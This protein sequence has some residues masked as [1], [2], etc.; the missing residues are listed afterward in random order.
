MEKS[1]PVQTLIGSKELPFYLRCLRSLL[2]NSE[3]RIELL[4]HTDKTFSKSTKD[5]VLA[6]FNQET[7]S[8]T[9]PIENEQKTLDH[10]SG[11]PLSQKIRRDSIWGI[12][13]FDPIFA[14]PNDPIS[15]YIDADILFLRPFSGLFNKSVV[16]GGALFIRDAQWDAYCIR[17]WHLLGIGMKPK[18]VQGITTALVCWDKR[19]IDWDYLEWFLGST[20]L[21]VIPEW[22]LPTAQAGLASMCDAKTISPHQ[23]TNLYP[24]A[25][26]TRD[27]FGVHLLGSYRKDW[28]ERLELDLE[29]QK[30]RKT[31]IRAR[32]EVC[33]KRYAF[34]YALNQIKRWVNTRLNYW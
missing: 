27:T 9:D 18:I 34:G 4:L 6:S 26:I 30:E 31:T 7:I 28:L 1:I 8:F 12:E 21:Q 32:F 23:I 22:I 25:H 19:C 33:K 24:N 20:H 14:I 10:L 13:F 5:T 16:E 17:P 2:E 15:F 29:H 11:Y 3:Q